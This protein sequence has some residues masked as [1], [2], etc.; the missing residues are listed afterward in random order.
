[1]NLLFSFDLF[2]SYNSQLPWISILSED[3]E[4]RAPFSWPFNYTW[5]IMYKWLNVFWWP[6]LLLK[7]AEN[8]SFYLSHKLPT[9]HGYGRNSYR[10]LPRMH[11]YVKFPICLYGKRLFYANVHN[12]V[13]KHIEQKYH[14]S[15]LPGDS[16][17]VQ[18]I[19]KCMS[20]YR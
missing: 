16:Y 1:M 8:F 4:V 11:K 14:M 15:L 6:K 13:I 10:R 2:L 7:C 9:A 19:H 18:P 3:G 5:R 17:L 12:W 20:I